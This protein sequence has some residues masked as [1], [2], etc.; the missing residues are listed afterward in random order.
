MNF[1]FWEILMLILVI[2]FMFGNKKVKKEQSR[3]DQPRKEIKLMKLSEKFP[4]G[5]N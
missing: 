1:G 3:K 4:F 2:Y 5:L